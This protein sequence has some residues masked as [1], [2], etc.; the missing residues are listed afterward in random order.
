MLSRLKEGHEEI[1]GVS[2]EPEGE[3]LCSQRRDILD[4]DRQCTY[5]MCSSTAEFSR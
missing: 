4:V 2:S 1:E 5:N 3:A